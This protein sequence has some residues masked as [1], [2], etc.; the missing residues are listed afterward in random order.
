[1][2]RCGLIATS[3]PH[4]TGDVK[5][6]FQT[7]VNIR[8]FTKCSAEK[9][10]SK[11]L[12][13]PEK[14][15]A[16][17]KFSPYP[18]EGYDPWYQCPILLSFLCILVLDDDINLKEKT[19]PL[20]EIY[21]KLLRCLYKKFTLRKGIEYQTIKFIRMLQKVGKI[22]F[23]TWISGHSIERS[24]LIRD[25]G[26]DAFNYGLIIGHEYSLPDERNSIY[27]RFLERGMQDF[28]R[29]YYFIHKLN[30]GIS[31]DTLLGPHGKNPILTMNPLFLH[32]CLWLLK[33]SE[34]H[35]SFRNNVQVYQSLQRF[36]KNK[37]IGSWD[38]ITDPS[39]LCE[40]L[41]I[42]CDETTQEELITDF[43]VEI[44]GRVEIATKDQERSEQQGATEASGMCHST[45]FYLLH[46]FQF[47]INVI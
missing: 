30:S 14:E 42:R 16:V 34:R 45:S 11:L 23:Q 41:N 3:R 12:N 38:Q 44:I 19:I 46:M 24:S 21:A 40:A 26:G 47:G 18:S 8:G 22:A 10:A 2:L 4:S 15:K 17:M 31:V 28:V 25:L 39:S 27:L 33:K 29:A 1:M 36:I 35:F 6:Y 13:D 20:G 7:V 43:F 37:L 9:F 32:F 5:G